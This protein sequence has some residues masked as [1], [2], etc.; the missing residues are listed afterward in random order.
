[1]NAQMTLRDDIKAEAA[2]LGFTLCGIT[3]PTP[4]MHYPVYEKWLSEG[5]QGSMA[6]LATE[7]VRQRR[8]NPK[9]ILD[10]C[11]SILTCGI[12]YPAP[13]EMPGGSDVEPHGKVGHSTPP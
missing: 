5:R 8:K 2:R 4:P 13:G 7:R 11:Q 12:R 10:N 1:M 9:L 3:S 6:Y